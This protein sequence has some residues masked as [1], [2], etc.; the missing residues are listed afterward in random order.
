M[1]KKWICTYFVLLL[2]SSAYAETFEK[3]YAP[4]GVGDIT[5]FIPIDR[6]PPVPISFSM[7]QTESDYLLAWD[8]SS[9]NRFKLEQWID[10]QWLLISDNILT[11]QYQTSLDNGP[12]FRVSACDQYGCSDWREVNNTVEGELM[13]SRFSGSHH[14]VE[15]GQQVSLSWEVSSAIEL[16]ITSNQGH[17]FTSYAE[18]DQQDFYVSQI[19][20]FTL[21]AT[22][23]EHTYTQTLTV[24]PAAIVTD[25][26]T[27]PQ[28]DTY[29]QPLLAL[30][31]NQ[32]ETMLPIERALLSITLTNGD[33]LNII[34][35][36]DNKLSRVS[37]NGEL[38]WTQT[39]NGMV[40]NQPILQLDNASQSGQLYF[41]VS[42]LNGT[43]EICRIHIDGSDLQCL[44]E[45]PNS[46][47]SLASMIAGPVIVDDRLFSFDI[48]G[49]LYEINIDP[50]TDFNSESNV[51]SYRYHAKVPLAEGDAILT[52]PVADTVNNSLILR[53]QL[54]N[55]IALDI[56]TTQ[57]SVSVLLQQATAF[58]GFDFLAKTTQTNKIAGEKEVTTD[59]TDSQSPA[60]TN[61]TLA[62]KWTKA[63]A[64]DEAR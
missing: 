56:P 57:S 40:A 60:N 7:T 27:Q 44:V 42:S 51:N 32:N 12:Q 30:V 46:Q 47:N 13:I 19:T 5:I 55:V 26:Q 20:E 11:N 3:A 52:P 59:I 48:N 4:I 15:R 64:Q 10:G 29:T 53:T 17:R 54:D 39:L 63:L 6:Q 43:G 31:L 24:S 18:K 2:S 8:P 45:Q 9:A 34:P 36:Q 41:G 49:H 62:I 33:N 25:F 50:N 23:F 61:N 1:A 22:G 37:D 16:K 58:L 35:Q 14:A 21:T 38:I 28:Q